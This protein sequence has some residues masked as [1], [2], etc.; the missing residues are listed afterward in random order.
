MPEPLPDPPRGFICPTLRAGTLRGRGP[1]ARGLNT[2]N[3][4]VGAA[5]GRDV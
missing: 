2:G 5:W 4:V 1:T 3:V